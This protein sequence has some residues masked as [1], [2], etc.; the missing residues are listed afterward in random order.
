MKIDLTK[1][2][3]M[4]TFKAQPQHRDLMRFP[5]VQEPLEKLMKDSYSLQLNKMI[6]DLTKK[7]VEFKK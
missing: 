4:T 5:K 3:L 1:V 2:K 7:M 6:V